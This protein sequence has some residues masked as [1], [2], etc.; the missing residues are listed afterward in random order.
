MQHEADI[1]HLERIA[2]ICQDSDICPT[3]YK[4]DRGTVVVQGDQLSPGSLKLITLP[5]GE[6]AAEIPV[7]VLLE[8]ARALSA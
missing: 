2:G 3:V 4:T 8:A 6:T 5:S 7:S 1:Q